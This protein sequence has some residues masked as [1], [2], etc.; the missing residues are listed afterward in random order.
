[1]C[2][3]MTVFICARACVP[4]YLTACLHAWFHVCFISSRSTLPFKNEK[5]AT[6]SKHIKNQMRFQAKDQRLRACE[7]VNVCACIRANTHTH[8]HT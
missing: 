7:G 6:W 3:D 5:V 8:T 1:M 2:T 4:T